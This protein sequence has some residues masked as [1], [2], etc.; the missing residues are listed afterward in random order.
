MAGSV[1]RQSDPRPV[2]TPPTGTTM[3]EKKTEPLTVQ[4]AAAAADRVREIAGLTGL[5]ASFVNQAILEIGFH[6]LNGT[7]NLR[8]YRDRFNQIAADHAAKIHPDFA[9]DPRKTEIFHQC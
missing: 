1:S 7:G 2:S 9:N 4:V 8:T 5:P 6:A 3:T